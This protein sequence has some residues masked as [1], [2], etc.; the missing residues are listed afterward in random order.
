MLLKSILNR[1]QKFKGFV[2][3]S[4]GWNPNTKE[5]TLDVCVVPRTNSQARCG[6]CK[7]QAP[8]YDTQPDRRF[9]FIPLWGIKV[10]LVYAPR[11]VKCKHCGVRVEWMPWAVGKH[12]L[13]DSFAW[14][15]SSSCKPFTRFIPFAI[16][17]S[18]SPV[19][20]SKDDRWHGPCHKLI[21]SC[22]SQRVDGGFSETAISLNSTCSPN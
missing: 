16:A 20:A 10:F 3:Q 11:R 13:T 7:R 9:Q 18:E 15:L 1:V 21:S 4:I 2:Y 6:K 17:S 19:E 22:H 8:G 5:P 12:R 14:Y